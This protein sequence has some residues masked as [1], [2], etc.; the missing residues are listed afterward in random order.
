MSGG[1]QT[2]LPMTSAAGNEVP[3]Q[4]P[5]RRDDCNRSH[6]VPKCYHFHARPKHHVRHEYQYDS[7]EIPDRRDDG[8]PYPQE[9]LCGK[10]HQASVVRMENQRITMDPPMDITPDSAMPEITRTTYQSMG[11]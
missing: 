11:Q 7:Q 3:Y 2:T 10:C 1:G 6:E 9:D 8:T 5:K 4:N